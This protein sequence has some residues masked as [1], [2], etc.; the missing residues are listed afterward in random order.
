MARDRYLKLAEAGLAMPLAP[1]LVL[2]EHD[3]AE[4]IVNDGE[5]L[6]GVITETARRYRTPLAVPLMDLS[7]EKRAIA[8]ALGVSPAEAD[9]FHFDMPPEEQAVR[10]MLHRIGATPSL[11]MQATCDAVRCVARDTSLIPVG[12]VIGPFSLMTK[13]LDDPITLTYLAGTGMPASVIPEVGLYTAV[14]EL[15]S[16]VVQQ[17]ARMQIDAG[18]EAL[19]VAEPAPNT[20]YISPNQMA[21]HPAMFDDVV[22]KYNHRLHMLTAKNDVDL[23]FHCCGELSDA[24]LEKMAEL[25]PAVLSLG[26]SCKLPEIAHLIPDDVVLYGNLPSKQFYSDGL[27]TRD[28]V[29]AQGRQLTA[30]MAETGH[31]FILGTECDVLSV[32]G[33]RDT[34][35]GKVEAVVECSLYSDDE[36]ETRARENA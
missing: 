25:H 26:S 34:I 3:N 6:G 29:L 15:A 32:P 7:V 16:V 17:Y 21:T 18:A 35:R 2:H 30:E 23:I 27:I 10:R 11:R 1:D 24:M 33:C 12:M 14:L 5:A 19:V 8:R 28:D 22:M 13:L 9:A 36:I 20:V 4:A 31:P